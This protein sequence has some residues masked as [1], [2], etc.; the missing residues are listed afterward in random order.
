MTKRGRL[1]LAIW[2]IVIVVTAALIGAA[3]LNTAALAQQAKTASIPTDDLFWPDTADFKGGG[4]KGVVLLVDFVKQA[5]S[6][7]S[8]CPTDVDFTV[9]DSSPDKLWAQTMAGVRRD[10]IVGVLRGFGPSVRVTSSRS[11]NGIISAVIISAQSAKDKEK[12]KLDTTSNPHKGKKVK[13][14]DKITVT[15]VARTTPIFGRAGS[16]QFS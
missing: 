5:Q 14:G 8:Q 3:G 7:S 15:M 12:P 4:G 13:A 1:V 11:T 10:A 6:P 9:F 16:R 2:A